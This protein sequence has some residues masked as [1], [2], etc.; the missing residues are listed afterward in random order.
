M[1]GNLWHKLTDGLNSKTAMPWSVVWDKGIPESPETGLAFTLH[2]GLSM[3]SDLVP[4]S[5]STTSRIVS[6]QFIATRIVRVTLIQKNKDKW[7]TVVLS[8]NWFLK[9][10]RIRVNGERFLVYIPLRKPLCCQNTVVLFSL[11][12]MKNLAGKKRLL[13]IVTV[14][15][16]GDHTRSIGGV[17]DLRI[18]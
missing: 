11:M 4:D 18:C 14:V 1:Q 8:K 13:Y 12:F 3:H 2:H 15:F 10:N 9:P 17:H 16:L 6:L 7:A 5:R